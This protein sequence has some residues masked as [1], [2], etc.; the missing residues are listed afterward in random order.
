MSAE[1]KAA[2]DRMAKR[3]GALF[4]L[5]GLV[6]LVIGVSLWSVAAGFVVGGLACIVL[7]F[8]AML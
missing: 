8:G 6:A 2:E 4:V 5:V 7:G 1:Q 3:G